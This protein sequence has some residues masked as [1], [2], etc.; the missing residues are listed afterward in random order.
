MGFVVIMNPRCFP[1]ADVFAEAHVSEDL[2]VNQCWHVR[3]D[4]YLC[5]LASSALKRNWIYLGYL[6]LS[7]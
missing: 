1:N 2:A 5:F 4:V 7:E 3:S 6:S